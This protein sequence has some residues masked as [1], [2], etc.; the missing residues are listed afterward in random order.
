MGVEASE[1]WCCHAWRYEV[2]GSDLYFVEVVYQ[3]QWQ[4]K[5]DQRYKTVRVTKENAKYPRQPPQKN[6]CWII[7]EIIHYRSPAQY[8]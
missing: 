2:S 4:S 3:S 7:Q 1:C 8:T 6:T 5:G